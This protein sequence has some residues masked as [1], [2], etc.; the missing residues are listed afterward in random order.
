MKSEFIRSIDVDKMTELLYYHYKARYSL[1]HEM[2]SEFKDEWINLYNDHSFISEAGIKSFDKNIRKKLRKY[3][4]E[5]YSIQGKLDHRI[6]VDFFSEKAWEYF[7]EHGL[8]VQNGKLFLR[9]EHIIPKK[10]YIQKPIEDLAKNSSEITFK[11]KN[12]IKERIEEYYYVALI[13]ISEDKE[14]LKNEMPDDWDGKNIFARY[15]KSGIK[16]IRNPLFEEL[17]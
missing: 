8:N 15:E 5:K 9:Y 1:Y 12:E 6:E 3:V 17:S 10:R 4:R 13:T 16:L 14:L 2:E 11:L 7:K